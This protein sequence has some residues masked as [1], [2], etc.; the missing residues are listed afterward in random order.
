M[1]TAG[2][3]RVR[4]RAGRVGHGAGARPAPPTQQASQPRHAVTVRLVRIPWR[5]AHVEGCVVKELDGRVGQVQGGV[6]EAERRVAQ[7]QRRIG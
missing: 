1:M 5:Y 2:G 6:P 7:R 4:V 3:V